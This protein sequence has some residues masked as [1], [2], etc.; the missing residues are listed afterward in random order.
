MSR[1]NARPAD[2]KNMDLRSEPLTLPE[3]VKTLHHEPPNSKDSSSADST[4]TVPK[5]SMP[6]LDSSN[7]VGRTFLFNKEGGKRL[8]ANIVQT[9][10]DC[11]SDLAR[12]LIE[13]TFACSKL[14]DHINKSSKDNLIE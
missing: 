8:R 13:G 9:I 10:D 12:D 14:L 7:L 1:S 6:I 3:V 11:K 4:N 5:K 2:N